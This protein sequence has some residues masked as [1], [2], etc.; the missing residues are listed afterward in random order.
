MKKRRLLV[1]IIVLGLFVLIGCGLW[2]NNG[3]LTDIE[4]IQKVITQSHKTDIVILGEDILFDV[5]VPSRKI[6]ALTEQNVERREDCEYT[7]LIINDLS[8]SVELSA[9]EQE[10]ATELI[11][12]ND[13]CLIYLGEKYGVT[14]D[15]P[16]QLIA[17][18]E[19]NLFFMYYSV[20]GNA[21][22]NVG[23]WNVLDQEQAEKYPYSLGGTL[24]YSFEYY[25]QNVT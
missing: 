11:S 17:S 13:F 23:S 15:D 24:M 5:D 8:D 18:V 4:K 6:D 7:I 9:E 25:L 22:R 3:E 14:W 10:L 2:N 16:T 19:G 1:A 21:Y 20:N 12:Q